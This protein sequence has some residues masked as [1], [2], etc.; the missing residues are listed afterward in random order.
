M[1]QSL[2]LCAAFCLLGAMLLS[3]HATEATTYKWITFK[4]QGAGDA[5][6]VS[7]Q[8]FV[9]EFAKRTK[10]KH[11]I[12]VFWGGSVAKTGEI[13]PAALHE[14]QNSTPAISSA[15]HYAKIVQETA[16]LRQLIFAAATSPRSRTR[17]SS[18][19]SGFVRRWRARFASSRSACSASGRAR[20]RSSA[21]CRC[22]GG[23]GDVRRPRNGR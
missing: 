16:L 14:L 23:S 13:P 15:G 9:D 10:G 4:P 17:R 19:P 3:P 7:T 20:S 18:R 12:Q 21:R 1:K 11:N 22:D 5:Q 2:R 6:A 8:W